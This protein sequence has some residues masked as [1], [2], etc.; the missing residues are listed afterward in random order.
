MTAPDPPYVATEREMLRAFL[1]YYRALLVDKAGGLTAEQLRTR[2]EPST[3]TLGGIVHHM[4]YVE[5][6]WFNEAFAGN[7]KL[8]PWLSA[9]WEE[10]RDWEFTVAADLDPD[11]I[12][13]R[14]NAAIDLSREIES[15]VGSVD[16]LA[17]LSRKG[18]H[19]SLRWILVH[20]IEEYAR[21]TGHADLIRESIDGEVGD[22]RSA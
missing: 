18:E 13:D 11:T 6:W 10:D 1:D 5:H 12:F 9:P 21:H 14:Y 17:V 22:F 20:M 15:G 3:L 19:W 2:L 16:D 7:E 8:E 4:A